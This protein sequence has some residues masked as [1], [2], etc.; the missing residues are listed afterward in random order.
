MREE[1]QLLVPRLV[2][3]QRAE[4]LRDLLELW[5]ALVVVGRRAQPSEPPRAR[6]RREARAE[7][8]QQPCRET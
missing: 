6:L 4:A 2:I 8:E 5:S 1:E 7:P 3:R